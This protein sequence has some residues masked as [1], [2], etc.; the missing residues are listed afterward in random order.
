MTEET[1][2][3]LMPRCDGC[4]GW[5][6]F[7]K[8]CPYVKSQVVRVEPIRNGSNKVVFQAQVF[9]TEYFP[10]RMS[11]AAQTIT[12]EAELRKALEP[13]AE[14]TPAAPRTRKKE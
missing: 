14:P 7:I 2:T 3:P 1:A 13:E 6:P 8:P 4:G 12:S 5:H 11:L 10:E 9:E